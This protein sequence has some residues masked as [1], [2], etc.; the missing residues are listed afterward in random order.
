M[1]EKVCELGGITLHGF[2]KDRTD[3]VL[4]EVDCRRLEFREFTLSEL[5]REG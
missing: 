4:R 3:Q 1:D 2:W 5:G